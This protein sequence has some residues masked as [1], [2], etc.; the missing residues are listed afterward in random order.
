[1]PSNEFAARS[2]KSLTRLKK[3]ERIFG[4]VPLR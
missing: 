3:S 2:G 1:V 4:A